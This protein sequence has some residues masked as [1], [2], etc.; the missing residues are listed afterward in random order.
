MMNLLKI[1]PFRELEEVSRRF[2]SYLRA[3]SITRRN[4]LRDID[5]S[6]LNAAIR[7]YKQEKHLLGK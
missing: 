1:N 7:R 2:K 5:Y 4:R 6:G 3:V